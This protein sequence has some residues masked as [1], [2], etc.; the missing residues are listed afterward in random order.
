MLAQNL[1]D[2]RRQRRL[3]VIDVPDGPHVYMRLRAIKLFLAHNL[4]QILFVACAACFNLGRRPSGSSPKKSSNQ[5]SVKSFFIAQ[6]GFLLSTV[7]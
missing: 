2:C 1:R 4:L 3:A 7:H 6:A 5:W